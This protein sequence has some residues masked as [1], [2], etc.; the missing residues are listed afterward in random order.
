[1]PGLVAIERLLGKNPPNE[2]EVEHFDDAD[3]AEAESQS[4]HTSSRGY[5]TLY[6][7]TASL[8]K[9]KLFSK[10]EQKKKLISQK[11]FRIPC[12]S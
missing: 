2:R 10:I 11:S 4:E 6:L 7:I 8:N 9:D 12:N 5:S 3:Q 1:M